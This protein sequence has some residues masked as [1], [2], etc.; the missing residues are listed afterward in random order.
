MF[1]GTFV[2]GSAKYEAHFDLILS[3]GTIFLSCQMLQEY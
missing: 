2:I 3:D 1:N